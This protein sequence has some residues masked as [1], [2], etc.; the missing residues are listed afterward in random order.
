MDPLAPARHPA[1]R[2]F[3]LPSLAA[4]VL[5]AGGYAWFLRIH[6]SP[7]AGGADSSG[8]LNSAALLRDG[9]FTAPV[10]P[11][12]GLSDAASDVLG[13]EPLGFVIRPG[14]SMMSPSYPPGL[15]L[16]LAAFAGPVGLDYAA[17][18][19]N[20]VSA[21]A[22]GLLIYLLARRL[23][24]PRPAAL[25][26]V[27]LLLGC[28]LFLFSALQPM[29]DVLALVWALAALYAALRARD[30]SRW[31]WFCG[32]AVALAVLV[33]PT[34][35]LLVLPVGLALGTR[36]RRFLWVALG[37]L[38]GA[39]LFAAYNS[40]V[41][42]SPFVTGYGNVWMAF[43]LVNAGPN[44]LHFAR[45]IPLL[46]G[47]VVLLA[48]AAPFLPAA[49]RR[50]WLVLGSWAALL[51][52]FYAFYFHS[53]ETWWYLRFILP[54]FPVLIL[55]GLL[56]AHQFTTGHRHRNIILGL[57]LAASLAWE[58][59]L[60]RRLDVLQIKRVETTYPAAAAWARRSVP[61]DAAIICMQVSGALYFYT[62]FLLVRWDL[63]DVNRLHAAL[64][65]QPRPVFALL[66]RF[67]ETGAREK[68]GGRWTRLAEI[69]Q[70]T[71]WRVE[72]TPAT[73]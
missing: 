30:S 72:L 23:E 21:L 29:S 44:L 61:A 13:Q 53:G 31:A 35:L 63:A 8:Y 57:L 51:T 47:P 49:R 37:G 67:E 65:A 73:P 18:P 64:Q 42:G 56:A 28:P 19:L 62:D 33:R 58:V 45:W 69:G 36:W 54:A 52:G 38:P 71:A 66:Y 25:G 4:V 22:G 55:A 7:F 12:P 16:H 11:L 34:N 5:L 2:R 6:V 48:L 3:F 10:R 9:R 26:G 60:V 43:G 32:L 24:L 68:L 15:P 27:A 46:L 50:D 1:S 70:A 59:T 40:E 20:I 17:I 14:S 41:Y 39:L